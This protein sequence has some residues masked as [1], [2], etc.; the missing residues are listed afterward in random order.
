[1]ITK[2]QIQEIK[3]LHQKKFRDESKTFIVEG[4]KSVLELLRSNLKVKALWSTENWAKTHK[5]NILSCH[6]NTLSLKEME[7]IS[8]LKT[9]QESLAIVEIP[10]FSVCDIDNSA[11]LLILDAIRDPGNFGTI[12][13]T[14]D[15]FGITQILASPDTVELTNPKTIQA[16]MGA[17][18]RVKI[19]YSDLAEYLTKRNDAPLFGTFMQ[20][21][22]IS[23]GNFSSNSMIL[24][25]NEANGI[26]DTL[27]P[28]ITEKI[29]IPAH[30]HDT[31]SLN[32]SIATAIVLYEFRRNS[33]T[34]C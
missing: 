25:G 17:F 6:F 7:R 9:P 8:T 33:E 27:L 14:A 20:G 24:I 13:R 1:M 16:S 4:T 2:T 12:I 32:A 19:I 30:S 10:V 21:T 15:W 31:E 3:K 22:P 34:K 29:S 11:P 5:D 28:F 18:A 23:Q 26:S